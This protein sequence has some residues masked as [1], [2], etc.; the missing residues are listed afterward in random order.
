MFVPDP[1]EY[2]DDS[3]A[4]L[5][6]IWENPL[7]KGKTRLNVLV[8]LTPQFHGVGPHNFNPTYVWPYYGMLVGFDPVAVDATGLRIIEAKRRDFFAEDRPLNPPAKHI[9]AA[10]TRYHLG[11]ADP[12]GIEVIKIG[13]DRDALI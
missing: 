4:R 9:L 6:T 3:C 7:V 8:M 11:T 5:A 12:A 2:H 10:D 13:D 1:S